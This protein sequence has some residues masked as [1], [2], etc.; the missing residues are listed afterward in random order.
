MLQRNE[1]GYRPHEMRAEPAEQQRL[2]A[3]R[4]ADE[5]EVEL[6]EV[7]ESSMNQLARS[8]RRPGGPITLFD[9]RDGES[10]TRGIEGSPRADDTSADDHDVEAGCGRTIEISASLRRVEPDRVQGC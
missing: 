2:F 3:Q 4:F 9:Q 7:A 1:E 5:S 6:F 8:A 10:T